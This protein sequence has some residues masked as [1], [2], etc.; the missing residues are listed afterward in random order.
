MTT[1]Q[2][3]MFLPAGG[4]KIPSLGDCEPV[5]QG[6]YKVSM[7]WCMTLN[8]YVPPYTIV[9]GNGQTIVGHID[10]LAAAQLVMERLNGSA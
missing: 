10:N 1:A 4:P 7:L 8:R 3:D 9:A 2:F 5:P 6:P